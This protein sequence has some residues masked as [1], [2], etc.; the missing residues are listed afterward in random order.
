VKEV[1][2]RVMLRGFFYWPI[3]E[4]KFFTYTDVAPFIKE[5]VAKS[6]NLYLMPQVPPAKKKTN[7]GHGGLLNMDVCGTTALKE[8]NTSGSRRRYRPRKRS[9]PKETIEHIHGGVR[10]PV[11]GYPW[12]ATLSH[13]LFEKYDYC[14]ATLISKR[15][16]ITGA[17]T[18]KVHCLI[19]SNFLYS[20]MCSGA[21]RF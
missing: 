12:H 3:A 1:N 14:G 8:V 11:S 4:R 9:A 20:L 7:F 21:L 19:S 13:R 10:A 2:N 16:A 6:Y 15:A 17:K 5:L 18:I